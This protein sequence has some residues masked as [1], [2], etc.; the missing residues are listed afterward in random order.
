[1]QS[2]QEHTLQKKEEET[3]GREA[4]RSAVVWFSIQARSL[5]VRPLQGVLQSASQREK[6]SKYL[7]RQAS[8]R[9]REVHQYDQGQTH[10]SSEAQGDAHPLGPA[11]VQPAR[12]AEASLPWLQALQ[13]D[14]SISWEEARA[15]TEMPLEEQEAIQLMNLTEGWPLEGPFQPRDLCILVPQGHPSMP[16]ATALMSLMFICYL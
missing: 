8:T 15:P 9:A 12:Q 10:P 6:P 11:S 3:S 5:R 7:L 16:T 4:Y 1:M 13:Q 14:F 2:C